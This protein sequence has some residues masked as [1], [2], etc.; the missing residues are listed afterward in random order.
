MKKVLLLLI[1]SLISVLMIGCTG[2]SKDIDAPN[3]SLETEVDGV[4][5][6]IR[7]SATRKN[8]MS[9]SESEIST[10]AILT[11]TVTA[12]IEGS[13]ELDKNQMIF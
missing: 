2:V 8:S 1:I 5:T 3:A 4:V 10:A 7:L 6:G 13:G 12:T 11:T 9:D